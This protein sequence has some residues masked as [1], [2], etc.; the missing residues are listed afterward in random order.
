LYEEA[1]HL[2]CPPRTPRQR[3]ALASR[4]R[5]F[6]RHFPRRAAFPGAINRDVDIFQLPRM[7][8]SDC[9]GEEFAGLLLRWF[10][11]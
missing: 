8:V 9:D 5:S 2:D 4:Q 6:A 11:G 10:L 3:S 1:A 7:Q